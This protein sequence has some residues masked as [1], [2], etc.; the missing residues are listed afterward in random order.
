MKER[1]R[2]G[3]SLGREKGREVAGR[4]KESVDSGEKKGE[5]WGRNVSSDRAVE[6]VYGCGGKAGE[7]EREERGER[8]F[9]HGVID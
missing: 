3:M 1:G 9:G 8:R 5:K 7:E 6:F 2:F 4:E